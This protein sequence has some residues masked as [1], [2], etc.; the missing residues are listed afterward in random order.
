MGLRGELT[1]RGEAMSM[2]IVEK[3]NAETARNPHARPSGPGFLLPYPAM[4]S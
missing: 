4:Y 2:R 1:A 3:S